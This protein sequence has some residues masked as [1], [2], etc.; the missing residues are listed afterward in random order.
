MRSLEPSLWPSLS[1]VS[2]VGGGADD[3]SVSVCIIVGGALLAGSVQ[4]VADNDLSASGLQVFGNDAGAG[5]RS[6]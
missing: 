3:E 5:E 2:T 1:G 4:L 6:G